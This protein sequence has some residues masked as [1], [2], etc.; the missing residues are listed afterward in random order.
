M[1]ERNR[2]IL[3]EETYASSQCIDPSLCRSRQLDSCLP[4]LTPGIPTAEEAELLQRPIRPSCAIAIP[5]ALDPGAAQSTSPRPSRLCDSAL[6]PKGPSNSGIAVPFLCELCFVS[7][8]QQ[9][10]A[11]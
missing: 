3:E 2:F 7:D 1:Q 10:Q 6:N 8:P 9:L 5:D 4:W 11:P